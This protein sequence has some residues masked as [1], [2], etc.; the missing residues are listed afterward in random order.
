[1]K[2]DRY[3]FFVALL[4]CCHFL[5]AQSNG[6]GCATP[7]PQG[8]IRTTTDPQATL[9]TQQFSQTQ[10]GPMVLPVVCHVFHSYSTPEAYGV[11]TNVSYQRI[12]DMINNTNMLLRKQNADTS[13]IPAPFQSLAADCGIELCLAQVDPSGNAM[14]EAGVDRF[15]VP[16]T[17]IP[18]SAFQQPTVF[19]A[20]YAA[21]YAWDPTRYFNVWIMPQYVNGQSTGY[22]MFPDSSGLA[23]LAVSN[24]WGAGEGIYLAAPIVNGQSRV[25]I[26]EIGHFLGLRHIWGDSS[27]GDDYCND[28]PTASAANLGCV[29]F[30]HITCSNGPNGDMFTNYMDY[31]ADACLHQFTPDQKARMLTVLANSPRRRELLSSTVCTP[32]TPHIPVA[33]FMN[34]PATGCIGIPVQYTDISGYQPTSWS[35]S[36]P[37]G[38]PS[39]ST[40]QYPLV[41]YNT[42]GMYSATLIVTN[43]AGSDTITL[44]NVV[45]INPYYNVFPLSEDFENLAQL[46]MPDWQIITLPF[47][48]PPPSWQIGNASAY[49]IGS[50]AMTLYNW[51]AHPI[52]SYQLDFT[53]RQHPELTFDYACAYNPNVNPDYPDSIM[54]KVSTDCGATFPTIYRL[55]SAQANTAPATSNF[56]PTPTQWRTAQFDLSAYAGMPSVYVEITAFVFPNYIWMDNINL[57]DWGPAGIAPVTI[58]SGLQVFPNPSADGNTFVSTRMDGT[59]ELF[60]FTGRSFGS[61]KI[62]ANK[63]ESIETLFGAQLPAGMYLLQLTSDAGVRQTIRL[64]VARN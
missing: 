15:S 42:P 51:N 64:V 53:N 16:S 56:V 21:P 47:T 36:F 37:G 34:S 14:Y 48:G 25:M 52:R 18:L 6:Y 23:G 20:S 31:S 22:G 26:H 59:L 1:M 61:V 50:K 39:T 63:Q 9:R 32:G 4:S 44:N 12:V 5:S 2:K 58:S 7:A 41:T 49:G 13:Q 57:V 62:Q 40:Q 11:G 17:G 28:T 43:A 10:G 55:D 60:D 35:W 46:P 54:V 33:D 45:S 8:A 24:N 27:C 30:P 29:A 38:T 19:S 3:L